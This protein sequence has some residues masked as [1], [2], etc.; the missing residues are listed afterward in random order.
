MADQKTQGRENGRGPIGGELLE[1]EG[2]G[3]QPS[4]PLVLLWGLGAET[5]KGAALHTMFQGIGVRV[6]DVGAG[7][8]G[9]LVGYLAELPGYAETPGTSGSESFAGDAAAEEFVLFCHM[10]D[11]QVMGFVRLMRTAGLAVGCKA[12]LTEHNRSWTFGGLLSEVA[13]EHAAMARMRAQASEKAPG[14]AQ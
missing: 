12:A 5:P 2:A 1:S 8:L 7:Q 14:A 3:S 9:E 11:D 10:S 6:R 4:T 13:Q